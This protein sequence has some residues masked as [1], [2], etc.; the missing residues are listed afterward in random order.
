MHSTSWYRSPSYSL[1]DN[2]EHSLPDRREHIVENNQ[3][4]RRPAQRIATF[5][6][7]AKPWTLTRRA[8]AKTKSIHTMHHIRSAACNHPL[9][10]QLERQTKT[11][12]QNNYLKSQQ[13]QNPKH[14]LPTAVPNPSLLSSPSIQQQHQMP[15]KK[16]AK[17]IVASVT[18][19]LLFGGGIFQYTFPFNCWKN[20]LELLSKRI[21]YW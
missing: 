17:R 1:P 20:A 15:A 18:R 2:R 11:P 10:S 13:R 5:T 21:S 9:T 3:H 7:E 19:R 8:T 16:L 6:D 12:Q 14:R 4:H